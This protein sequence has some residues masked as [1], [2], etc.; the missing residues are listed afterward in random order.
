MN[1]VQSYISTIGG[2]H[3]SLYEIRVWLK[4]VERANLVLDGR[5]ACKYTYSDGDVLDEHLVIEFACKEVMDASSNHYDLVKDAV[6]NLSS[7]LVEHY[8]RSSRTWLHS[9]LICESKIAERSGRITIHVARWVF[10]YILNFSRGFCK[11]YLE[12]ALQLKRANSIIMYMLTCNLQQ[13]ISYNIDVLKA[14]TGD[15]DKYQNNHDYLKKVIQVACDD[16]A[17]NNLNGYTYEV[18]KRGCKIICL[19]FRPVKRQKQETSELTA[20]LPLTS[21]CDYALK[22]Y[23]VNQ[24]GFSAKELGAHKDLLNQFG[25]LPGWQEDLLAIVERQRKKRAGKGYIINAIKSILTETITGL[26]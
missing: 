4:I 7:H 26:V 10:E 9:P 3:M 11:Y 15:S 24:C 1:V 16:L 13:T 12:S 14:I 25:R 22:S 21:V 8:D 18:I 2:G 19:E 5:L 20:Q 17:A 23:L 6:R